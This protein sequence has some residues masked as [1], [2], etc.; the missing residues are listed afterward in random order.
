MHTLG[1]F[2]EDGHL[3]EIYYSTKSGIFLARN[4]GWHWSSVL[5]DAGIAKKM[6]GAADY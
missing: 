6:T 4:A 3:S 2:F 1:K 5:D